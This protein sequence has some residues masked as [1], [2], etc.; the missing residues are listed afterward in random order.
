MPRYDYACPCGWSTEVVTTMADWEAEVAS[1][2]SCGGQPVRQFTA[3]I[4][5]V[6]MTDSKNMSPSVARAAARNKRRIEKGVADGS[7]KEWVPGKKRLAEF[8]PVIPK[9]LH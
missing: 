1:C 2:P 7:I 9:R 3:S 8:D 4:A 6:E 5:I